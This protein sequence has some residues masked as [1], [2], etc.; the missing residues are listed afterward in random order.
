MQFDAIVIGKGPAGVSAAVYLLRAGF[1]VGVIATDYGALERTE[2]IENFYGFPETISGKELAERGEAQAIRLGAT[3]IDDEVVGAGFDGAFAVRTKTG[4][5]FW[6]DALIFAPGTARKKPNVRDLEKYEGRGVSYCAVCDAFFFRKKKVAVLGAGEYAKSE[7]NELK[8]LVQSVVVLTDGQEPTADFDVPVIKKKI[9]VLFADLADVRL[10]GAFF[11]DG[12]TEK[13][14]GLFV[15]VG[16]AGT[17]DLA[18]KLGAV[19]ENGEIV[20]DEDLAASV[21]GVFA[22]GDCVPGVKQVAK[23]VAD[24]MAAAMS[25]IK[26]LRQRSR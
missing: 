21:P 25:A 2:K 19:V 18:K 9:D 8:P 12:T 7:V 22:A 14:E 16:R 4:K 17:A 23:A 5:D 3:I 11:T 24:G 15:A 20:V 13:F 10:A 1:S 26:Y 6:A